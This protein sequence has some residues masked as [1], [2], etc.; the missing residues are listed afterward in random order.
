MDMQALGNLAA[1]DP[2]VRELCIWLNGHEHSI[3]TLGVSK[4]EEFTGMEY[5]DLVSTFKELD[6]IGAGNFVVGRKGHDSRIVWKYDTKIIG[7]IGR[8]GFNIFHAI[9]AGGLK[10]VPE[11]AVTLLDLPKPANKSG[12]IKHSL[13]LRKDFQVDL[14]LPED[15]SELELQK[16]KN[17]LDLLV[18]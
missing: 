3:K 9:S 16:L 5:Y 17:W 4:A 10:G 12:A 14:E 13:N 8:N 18:Y 1:E 6:K 15:I 11:G 7:E 2:L